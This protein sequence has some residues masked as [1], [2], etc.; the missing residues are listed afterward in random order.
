ML[1]IV[2]NLTSHILLIP[3]KLGILI[4]EHHCKTHTVFRVL[5]DSAR[6]TVETGGIEPPIIDRFGFTDAVVTCK[7]NAIPLDYVPIIGCD[8]WI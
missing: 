4:V 8:K 5:Y 7:A 2:L 3:F 1:E 6:I